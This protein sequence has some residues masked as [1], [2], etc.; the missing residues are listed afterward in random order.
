MFVHKMEV[1][2][3]FFYRILGGVLCISVVLLNV[4]DFASYLQDLTRA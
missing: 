2:A 3:C 1:A 4:K